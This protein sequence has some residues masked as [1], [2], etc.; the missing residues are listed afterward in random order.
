MCIYSDF[1]HYGKRITAIYCFYIHS[2]MGIRAVY[3][4]G[5]W[6]RVHSLLFFC[7][8]FRSNRQ[9]LNDVHSCSIVKN[10][11]DSSEVCFRT[12]RQNTF[13]FVR[14]FVWGLYI[15]ILNT[16]L[17]LISFRV[18]KVLSYDKFSKNSKISVRFKPNRFVFVRL[19]T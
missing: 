5:C 7:V 10:L 14:S 16:S 11:F 1:V 18:N 12:C 3:E 8:H 6:V 9:A 4:R 2:E 17:S 19:V 15:C 13:M